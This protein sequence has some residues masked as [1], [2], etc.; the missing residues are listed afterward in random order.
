MSR[1]P[2][3]TSVPRTRIPLHGLLSIAGDLTT[4]SVYGRLREHGYD[5][6]RPA[7]GCVFGNVDPDGSRLTD[8]AQRAGYTKQTVGEVVSELEELG[9]V[10]RVPDPEDRRAKLI[11]LTPRG[12]KAQATGRRV[13]ADLEETWGRRYGKARVAQLR[14]LLEE[15]LGQAEADELAA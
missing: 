15:V 12:R 2:R 11:R 4:E 13:I 9:Y 10:E 14:A 6:V 5:D 7:H 8:L 1:E 3:H